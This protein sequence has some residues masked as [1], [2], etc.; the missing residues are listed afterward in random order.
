M[1]LCDRLEAGRV[2]REAVR[3]RLAAASLARL[4]TPDPEPASFTSH[5]RFALNTLPAL[6]TRADQIKA[7]RQTI[8]NLAVRGKLVAQ[9]ASDE[10][11]SH[12]L[13]RIAKERTKLAAQRRIPPLKVATKEAD[14]HPWAEPRGWETVALGSVCNF[15]TSG[16]RGWGE[17]YADEGPGFIRAQNIRPGSVEVENLARVNPPAGSE[18]AR[19][20][21]QIDDLLIV[22]TGAGVTNAGR[23]D[24]DLG[25][26]YVSQH[27]GLAGC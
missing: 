3:D 10:A 1:A 7:L 23:L 14:R 6:S 19:T 13:S 12:L 18:G 24:R 2:A 21:V 22:I 9:D 8:L 15:V 16:S 11:A 4:N 25:E 20:R 27:V 5:A 26:A 17:F